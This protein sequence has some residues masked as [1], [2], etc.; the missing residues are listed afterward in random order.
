MAKRAYIYDLETYSNMFLA[1]F[2]D[3]KDPTIRYDF[4]ISRRKNEFNTLYEFLKTKCGLLIGY[5]NTG[6]DYPIIHNLLLRKN[7]SCKHYYN[8]AGRLISDR[9]YGIN[10]PLIPQL[11]LFKIWHLDNKAVWPL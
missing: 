3:I 10:N 2:I 1:C 5:N 11:D 6:F 8:L 9:Q 7:K 4:E